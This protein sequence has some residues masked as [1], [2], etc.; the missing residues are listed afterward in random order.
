MNSVKETTS[1]D[2]RSLLD[3]Y[4]AVDRDD[5]LFDTEE[6][7]ER[8]GSLF[9]TAMGHDPNVYVKTAGW[10]H[11]ICWLWDFLAMKAVEHG[12]DFFVLMGDDVRLAE[13]G[14]KEEVRSHPAATIPVRIPEAASH[15]LKSTLCGWMQIEKEFLDISRTTN[16]PFGNNWHGAGGLQG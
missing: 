6:G 16:L 9:R 12:A 14:W 10:R 13:S 2:D 5:E 11:N 15:D 3:V 8:L 7:K 4:I 1:A